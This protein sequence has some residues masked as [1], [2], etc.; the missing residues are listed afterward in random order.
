MIFQCFKAFIPYKLSIRLARRE[1]HRLD[2]ELKWP[3]FFDS[4]LNG[5]QL[6]LLL[7]ESGEVVESNRFITYESVWDDLL[8]DGFVELDWIGN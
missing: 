7:L 3:R 4:H 1:S 8:F 6:G 5:S 2:F